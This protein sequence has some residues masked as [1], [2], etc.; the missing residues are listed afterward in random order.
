MSTLTLSEPPIY[1]VEGRVVKVGCDQ[2]SG[3][4]E[5]SNEFKHDHYAS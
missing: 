1:D 3:A 5:I 2:D 4:Q